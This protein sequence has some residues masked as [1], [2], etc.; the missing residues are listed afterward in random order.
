M[1]NHIYGATMIRNDGITTAF[2]KVFASNQRE[3]I[4]LLREAYPEWT[5]VR[6]ARESVTR[7]I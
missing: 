4:K 2:Q 7:W 6:P 1:R 5:F 3:A